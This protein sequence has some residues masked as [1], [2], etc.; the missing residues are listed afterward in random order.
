MIL[1]TRRWGPEKTTSVVCIHGLTHHS[2][3]FDA[4]GQRLAG[5]GHSTIAVDLR[6]HGGSGAEP[7]WDTGTH[8]RDVI[9]TLDEAG[10]ERAI[11]IGHS[12]GGRVAATLAAEEPDRTG[13]VALLET[14][15]QVAPDR[16]LRAIEIER[17]DWSFAT[18]DGALGAMLSSDLMVAPPRDVVEAFVK[19]DVRP[20]PDG[21]LR[22]SFSPGVVVVAWN[23]MTLPPPPIARTPTL[24]VCAEKPLADTSERDRR[25][26][27]ELGELQKRV[28]V[29][30]GHNVLWEAPE[31][32]SA[33]IE[34]F[35]TST[36][37]L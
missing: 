37:A 12:Y 10:V 22:F 14:P 4:L 33:A 15:L 17:L 2:G 27:E 35:V 31:E 6:G 13:G 24:L 21:R 9:E 11:W 3:I 28:E 8:A 29:P 18:A 32:T 5:K 1:N 34:E 30:N 36:G 20:G 7:P 25:Y 16:A 26:R 19:D 23:E